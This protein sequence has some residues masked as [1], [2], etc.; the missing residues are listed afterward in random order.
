M[1]GMLTEEELAQ[2]EAA[3]GRALRPAV[4]GATWS[5]TTRVRS[6]M[7]GQ[8]MAGGGGQETGVSSWPSTSKPD[9]LVEISR[10]NRMLADGSF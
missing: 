6:L 8:L 4:P 3:Q 2:L 7:V 1:P 5:D 9:Q 10:M